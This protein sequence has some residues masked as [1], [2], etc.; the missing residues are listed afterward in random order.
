MRSVLC[1]GGPTLNSFLLAAGLVDELFLTLNPKLLGGA[2][3][4]TIVA[5][6]SSWSPPTL[7]LVSLAEGGGELF[8]RWRVQALK[9]LLRCRNTV[10]LR[11]LSRAFRYQCSSAW[12]R[13]DTDQARPRRAGAPA[14]PGRAGRRVRGR[15]QGLRRRLRR[16][17]RASMRIGRGEFVFLVGPTGC[18][19]STCIRLLHEGARAQRGRA[20]LIAGR[21]SR[22]CRASACPTC[23]ATSAWS[24]RTTS[25]SRTAR[26]TTTWPTR[27]R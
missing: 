12:P 16:A 14:R 22:T 3:A 19:K 25:C 9:S 6:R 7:E 21:A 13:F 10:H 4:L 1:E 5:G 18:G 23:A 8:T 17:R 2:A 27:S 20:S 26:S 15:Q 11:R 24:S